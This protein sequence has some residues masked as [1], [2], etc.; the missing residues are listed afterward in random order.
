MQNTT[1]NFQVGKTAENISIWETTTYDKC[2]VELNEIPQQRII[3]RP[4]NF[5]IEEKESIQNE[6]KRF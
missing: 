3:P 6:L 2:S 5:T 4:F 1:D